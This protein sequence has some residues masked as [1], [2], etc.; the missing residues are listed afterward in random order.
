MP[1]LKLADFEAKGGYLEQGPRGSWERLVQSEM[2]LRRRTAG[3]IDTRVTIV[4]VVL[5]SICAMTLVLAEIYRHLDGAITGQIPAAPPLRYYLIA[6][7]VAGV[8]IGVAGRF[9]SVGVRSRSELAD[10]R[11]E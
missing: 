2:T 5:S 4:G 10:H 7:I 1:P 6:G 11:Y 8:A 9:T 3:V